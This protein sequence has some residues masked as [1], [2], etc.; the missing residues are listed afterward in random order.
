MENYSNAEKI[1]YL[2]VMPQCSEIY[3]GG[4]IEMVNTCDLFTP[5][6]HVFL[7]FNRNIYEKFCSFSNVVLTEDIITQDFYSFLRYIDRAKHVLLHS[8]TYKLKHLLIMKRKQMQKMVWCV[9]GHDLYRNNNARTSFHLKIK[10]RL[11]DL[12]FLMYNKRLTNFRGIGIGFKYDA[13]EVKKKFGDNLKIFT[14]P[15]FL[16]NLELEAFNIQNSKVNESVTTP[17][18]IMIG[19]SAFS[20]LNHKKMLDKLFKYKDKNILVSLVLS[21]GSSVY[22][23]EISDYA[24]K[25]FG[26]KV[27]I[28][29]SS[30]DIKD[31][32]RYL[33]TVDIAIFDH[34]HQS[35][36]SNIYYLLYLNKKIYLNKD[37]IIALGMKLEGIDFGYTDNIGE[38][39]Y[40]ELL[41]NTKDDKGQKFAKFY[42]DYTNIVNLWERTFRELEEYDQ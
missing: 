36:L 21:Y 38:I 34:K 14:T 20:F 5:E 9:W 10:Q 33:S 1:K 17:I 13:L 19:H 15:Y 42:I 2:H 7:V 31:Y 39:S 24:H 3:D 25:L 40:Q 27:E 6:D 41:N 29:R 22:C 4:I 28:I 11:L 23:K 37:G 26:S 16:K 12:Y 8:N 30:M 35:A 32:I 18:K